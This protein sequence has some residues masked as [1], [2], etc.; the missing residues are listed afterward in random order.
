MT[1]T[2]ERADRDGRR[3]FAILDAKQAALA[4]LNGQVMQQAAVLSF[5]DAWLYI[6][7]VFLGVSP[8]IL[9][10]R[11]PKAHTEMPSDAH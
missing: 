10:L 1:D 2:V 4:V 6:L 11:R 9:L 5:N 8:A 7:L 3:G